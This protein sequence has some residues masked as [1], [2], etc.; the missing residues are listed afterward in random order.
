MRDSSLAG[1]GRL[2]AAAALLVTAGCAPSP[3][4]VAGEYSIAVTSGANGCMLDNWTE[5][6]SSA[7]IPVTITQAEDSA[8]ADVGGLARLALDALL[9]GHVFVGAVDGDDLEL[10]IVGTSAFAD[11][12]CDYTYDATLRGTLDGDVLT[13]E[14]VYEAKTDGADTCGARTGCRSVQ[15]FNGTRPP[16]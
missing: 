13:G 15:S 11:G 2:L 4:D 10:V 6:E 3:A 1:P 9:G 5:G 7:N 8:A 12:T 14:I 16:T